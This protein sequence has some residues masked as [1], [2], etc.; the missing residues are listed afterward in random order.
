MLNDDD[1]NRAALL[2]DSRE[3]LPER[4]PCCLI[5]VKDCACGDRDRGFAHVL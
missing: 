3:Y 1:G 5:K 4:W 2:S